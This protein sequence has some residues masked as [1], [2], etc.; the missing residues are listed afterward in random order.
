MKFKIFK[1]KRV[2]ST[3]DVAI[4]LIKKKKGINGFIYAESQ[5][6]GRGTHGKKWI[7]DIGNLFVSIFFPLKKNYPKSN[8]FYLINS[9][10]VSSVI[11]EFCINKKIS[12]KRP[13]DILLNGKK[14]CGILQEVITLNKKKFLIVGVGINVISSPNITNKYKATNIL[15]ETKKRVNNKELIFILYARYSKFFYNLSSLSFLDTKDIT[16][17]I[18]GGSLD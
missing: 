14:V 2:T 15:L 8:E 13:N 7:S 4:D 18:D 17:M 6:K 10:I 9:A 16:A 11:K 3:N 5:N 12:F 1:F